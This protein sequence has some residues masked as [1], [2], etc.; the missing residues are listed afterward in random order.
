MTEEERAMLRAVMLARTALGM[1]NRVSAREMGVPS[2]A[3]CSNCRWGW[4]RPGAHLSP[5]EKGE[6]PLSGVEPTCGA[7]G[8]WKWEPRE[9]SKVTT[10]EEVRHE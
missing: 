5:C 2:Y 3:R 8:L 4:V 7:S 10:V 6:A 1:E 9:R